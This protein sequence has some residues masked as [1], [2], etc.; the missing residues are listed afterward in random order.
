MRILFIQAI[1]TQNCRELVFPLGLARLSAAL[2]ARHDVRGLDLNLDPFPWPNLIETLAGF[3]PQAVALSFR[4][5]DSLAGSLVSFVP[6]LKTLA[7][8]IHEPAP[9]SKII[10]GGSGFTLFSTRM[11]KE[12]PEA[13]MGYCGEADAEFALLI[14][15]LEAPWKVP[16]TIWRRNAELIGD[17]TAVTCSRSLDELP[18]PDWQL[19]N[20]DLYL[21]RNNYVTFMGVETKRGCPNNCRYAAPELSDPVRSFYRS[22]GQSTDWTSSGY[23]RGN[24]EAAD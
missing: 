21:H 15:N 12:V 1:S 14:A 7:A 11:M 16:G 17:G 4:N 8:L 2:D 24:P 6:Q 3:K 22:G 9:E 5:L 10:L 20:P 18:F 23:L 19:F 13:H